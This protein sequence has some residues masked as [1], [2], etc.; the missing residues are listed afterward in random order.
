[1]VNAAWEG[2]S[3]KRTWWGLVAAVQSVRCTWVLRRQTNRT[4][5]QLIPSAVSL[6]IA[7]AEQSSTGSATDSGNR[8]RVV[9][10]LLPNYNR[11]RFAGYL[12]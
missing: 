3:Q 4:P 7:E 12:R 8:A 11:V 9:L 1:M 2:E 6:R 5:T 10:N